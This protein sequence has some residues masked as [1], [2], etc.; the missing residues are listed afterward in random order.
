MQYNPAIFQ[1]ERSELGNPG[2]QKIEGL[3]CTKGGKRSLLEG[4]MEVTILRKHQ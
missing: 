2:Q 3:L 4:L 1:D